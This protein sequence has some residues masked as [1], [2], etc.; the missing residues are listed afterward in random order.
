MRPVLLLLVV[1]TTMEDTTTVDTILVDQLMV[2]MDLPFPIA[3][4]QN[5]DLD[6]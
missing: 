3:E 2:D 4:G 5:V 1:D 6:L